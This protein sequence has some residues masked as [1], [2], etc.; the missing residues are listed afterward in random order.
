MKSRELSNRPLSES[1]VD[2]LL[3]TTFLKSVQHFSQTDSTNAQATTFLSQESVLETPCLIYAESQTA[4]KGRGSNQWWSQAG[5]LTF[6]VIVD[7]QEFSLSPEQLIKLPLLTGLAV[8]RTCQA[9]SGDSADGEN[10]F[11]LKWPNDVYLCG[12]KL[13]GILIEVPSVKPASTT[14]GSSHHAIIGVGLN[15]NNTWINAPEDLRA[16]GIS[17]FDYADLKFDRLEILRIFLSQLETLIQSLTR[18]EPVLDDWSE[19]CLLTGKQVTLLI[20]NEEVS[21]KCLGLAP[22]GSL[23]LQTA[24]GTEQFLGGI[25]KTWQ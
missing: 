1:D 24:Q 23:L 7:A 18:G 15:I 25:V 11:A 21:G 13:A 20:G 4:G 5:S 2:G 22:N 6:S 16:K 17:L 14:E 8:L 19:H 9:V 3:D 10:S 12:R